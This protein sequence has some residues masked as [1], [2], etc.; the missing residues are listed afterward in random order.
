VSDI[1]RLWA[2]LM[3]G[4]GKTL[5]PVSQKRGIGM[6]RVVQRA[7]EDL[8]CNIKF[9]TVLRMTSAKSLRGT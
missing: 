1:E 6:A 2:L 9:R 7:N 4:N 5:S 8:N 3:R